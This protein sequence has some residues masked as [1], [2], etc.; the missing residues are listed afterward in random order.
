MISQHGPAVRALVAPLAIGLWVG[1]M[2]LSRAVSSADQISLTGNRVVAGTLYRQGDMY[3][4]QPDQGAAFKVPLDAVTGIVMGPAANTPAAARQAWQTLQGQIA[5]SSNLKKI[6][7]MARAYLKK[8]PHSPSLSAA[9]QTLAQYRKIQAKGWVKF[10][11]HWVS[12]ARRDEL[13]ASLQAQ[14]A[15]ALRHLKAGQ[16]ATARSQTAAVLK[17]FPQFYDALIVD[18]VAQYRMGYILAARRDFHHAVQAAPDHP[19]GW[20]DLAIV[21]FRQRLEPEALRDYA[22][23][24]PLAAGSRMLLDNI[25]AALHSYKHSR[26]TVLYKNLARS[27]HLADMQMQRKMARFGLYRYGDTWVTKAQF[28]KLRKRI[29]AYHQAKAALQTQYNTA[30]RDLDNTEQQLQQVAVQ[31]SNLT[32]QIVNLQVQQQFYA[33]QTGVYNLDTQLLINNYSTQLNAQQALQTKLLRQKD[34]IIAAMQQMRRVAHKMQTHPVQTQY[35]GNQQ[36]ML[37]TDLVPPPAKP[38]PPASG[39][40]GFVPRPGLIGLPVVWQLPALPRP[41]PAAALVQ[42]NAPLLPAYY[43]GFFTV[44]P[45]YPPYQPLG[46]P[47]CHRRFRGKPLFDMRSPTGR[48]GGWNGQVMVLP[49]GK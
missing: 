15:V 19:V 2:L 4:I 32:I 24:L 26:N 43:P 28:R 45:I 41:I 9:R 6:M 37:P 17:V 39:S 12:P 34:A 47:F 21:A 44:G 3:V 10:G 27:F 29:Q 49:E 42:D 11:G 16:W 14:T 13:L 8:Y 1:A 36:L 33:T 40:T 5:Q 46:Y 30:R 18:G 31:I 23:A 35:T 48:S 38:K 7:A 25:A 20:N 22:S